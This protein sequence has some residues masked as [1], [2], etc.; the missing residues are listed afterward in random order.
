MQLLQSLALDLKV[1]EPDFALAQ[2]K[3]SSRHLGLSR[4]SAERRLRRIA[5]SMGARLADLAVYFMDR[6]QKEAGGAAR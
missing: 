1:E 2:G 3:T 6:A 5:A 4:Y